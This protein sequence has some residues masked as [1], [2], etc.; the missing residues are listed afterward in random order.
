M[1]AVFLA[2]CTTYPYEVKDGGDGVYYAAS[3]PVY[4]YVDTYFG[5]PYYGPYSWSWYYPIWHAPIAGPHYSWY[6]PHCYW[7]HPFTG[8]NAR[9]AQSYVP[10]GDWLY[11]RRASRTPSDL[12]PSLTPMDFRAAT[13]EPLRYNKSRYPYRYSTPAM[14]QR[15]AAKGYGS[16][17]PS[18]RST[19]PAPRSHSSAPRQSSSS[20]R[21]APRSAPAPRARSSASSSVKIHKQ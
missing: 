21:A 15:M 16:N 9:V 12:T 19:S 20:A 2:G 5:F 1:L 3:P 4:R 8:P 17:K 10:R 6:R 7:C 13:I 14:K 11:E 18:S